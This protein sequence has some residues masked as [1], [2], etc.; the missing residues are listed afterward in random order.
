MARPEGLIPLTKLTVLY[1]VPTDAD[2]FDEHYRSTHAPLAK[3]IP[4]LHRFSA[5]RVIGTADGTPSPYHLVVDLEFTDLEA[6]ST[7]MGSPEGRA[8]AEDVPGFATGGV[9]LLITEPFE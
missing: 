6:L 7:G 9:N 4:Q 5:N 3:A 2:A 1:G 8:A